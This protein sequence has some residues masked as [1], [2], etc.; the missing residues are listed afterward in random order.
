MPKLRTNRSAKKRFK[1]TASGKVKRSHAFARHQMSAKNRKTKRK[2]RH[3]ALVAPSDERAVKRM[4][5]YL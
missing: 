4:L 1:L 5:P 2:L 3:A